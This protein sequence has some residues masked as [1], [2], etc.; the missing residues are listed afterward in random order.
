MI[1]FAI[2]LRQRHAV[3]FLRRSDPRIMQPTTGEEVACP[4]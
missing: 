2:A 3:K 1:K 4:C